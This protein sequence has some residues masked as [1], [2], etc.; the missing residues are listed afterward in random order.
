MCLTRRQLK[1]NAQLDVRSFLVNRQPKLGPIT[2]DLKPKLQSSPRTHRLASA[3]CHIFVTAPPKIK[4]PTAAI[5]LKVQ[6]FHQNE[7]KLNLHQRHLVTVIIKHKKKFVR[8]TKLKLNFAPGEK[9][10]QGQQTVNDNRW[11]PTDVVGHRPGDI[12]DLRRVTFTCRHNRSNRQ[13]TPPE[14]K[15]Q[16]KT[17]MPTSAA[18]GL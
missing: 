9:N 17:V 4:T 1:F 6:H 11:P 2:N 14:K 13:V 16:K 7:S 5:N 18:R 8:P 12:T 3:D 10:G 15:K